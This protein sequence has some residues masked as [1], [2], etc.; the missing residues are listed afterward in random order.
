MAAKEEL[1]RS[2]QLQYEIWTYAVTASRNSESPQASMLLLPALNSMFDI[3]TTRTQSTTIHPP[4]II[5]VKWGVVSLAA[6]LLAGHGMAASKV[7]SWVHVLM[8]ATTISLTVYVILEIEYP[9]LG[10]ITLESADRVLL[11][12][13]EEMK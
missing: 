5:F 7:R 3:V 4:L 6:A 2:L 13:R 12:L 10:M 9:R 8:F 11:E 1:K